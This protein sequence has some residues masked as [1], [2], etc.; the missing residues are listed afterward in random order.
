MP[1]RTESLACAAGIV[2]LL[3]PRSRLHC[4]VARRRLAAPATTAAQVDPEYAKLMGRTATQGK[5]AMPTPLDVG[6]ELWEH[7]ARA[8]LRST[9]RTTRASASSSPTPSRASLTGYLPGGPGRAPARLPDRHVAADEPGARSV[10][11]DHEAGF[12]A[13]LDAARALHDQGLRRSRRSS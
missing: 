7:L 1:M 10:H 6:D 4:G 12:A 11:P 9:A 13:R 5:S 2:S 8:L 3:D